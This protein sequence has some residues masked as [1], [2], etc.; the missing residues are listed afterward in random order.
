MKELYIGFLCLI[1]GHKE[2]ATGIFNSELILFCKR[3][4]DHP[5]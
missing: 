1:F 5:I 4:G 2:P 3:C